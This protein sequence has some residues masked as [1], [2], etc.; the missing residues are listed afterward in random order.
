MTTPA[1]I[2]LFL[3]ILILLAVS[4]RSTH[5]EELQKNATTG[6]GRV[7]FV[8]QIQPIL[9]ARC[10]ACHG[11]EAQEAGLRLDFRKAALAGGD[12]GKV[13]VAGRSGASPL[14]AVLLSEDEDTRMPPVD[15]GRPL[16]PQ[17]VALIRAWIDQGAHWPEGVD[18]DAA[19][20][21]RGDDHWAYQALVRPE[22]PKLDNPWIRNDVDRFVLHRLQKEDVVPSPAAERQT[23]I[24]RLHLDLIGLP[25][26]P[27]ELQKWTK[28]ADTDSGWYQALVDHLLDSPHFGERWGRHWLDLARYADSDGYEKDRPRP[29]AW[30]WRDWVINAVNRDLPFDRFTIE[31]LAGDLLPDA[32]IE[33]KIATGFHRNTLTNSEGGVDQ[34]E[35][36]IKAVKDRVYTTGTVWLGLT[37]QCGE[38]HSHKFDPFSQREYYRLAAFFNNADESDIAAM[39]PGEAEAHQKA[40]ASFDQRLRE[41]KQSLSEADQSLPERQA[42]WERQ[43]LAAESSARKKIPS[44]ILDVIDTPAEQRDG[45]QTGELTE[46]Y[47]KIDTQLV[48]LNKELDE[49]TRNKPK[50]PQ[51]KAPAFAER[52]EPRENYVH[53]RGDF[54]RRGETV[55]PGTLE[56]LHEF[57]PRGEYPDRLD[58]AHWLVDKANPLTPRVAANRIWQH[59]F[60]RGIVETT[61]DFGT[62]GAPPTH[63]ELIDWLATEYIRQG[64]S[65]K[66]MIRLIVSSATYRQSS[67]A[68]PELQDRDPKNDLIARQNRFRM[69]AEI[70]RDLY[71]ASSGLLHRAIGGRSV[72]PALPADVAALGYAGSVKWRESPAPDRYRRGMYIFFRRSVPYPMLT[73]FDAPE[74]TVVSTRRDRSNTPLQSLTLLND[75]VFV[76]CAQTLARRVLKEAPAETNA[77]IR[78]AFLLCLSREPDAFEMARLTQ[79]HGQLLTLY[80]SDADAAQQMC[81][82]ESPADGAN[83]LADSA[84]WTALC[85]ALMNLDEFV[86]RE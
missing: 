47:R 78:R 50:P 8:K 64:W 32:T 65:R 44:H 10:Y 20:K 17:E 37:A 86:T 25:P 16:T 43:L 76:E 61:W 39:L 46:F 84:A 4:E 75:P 79:L 53:Q 72:Y 5:A 23:L 36:R 60:G 57:N 35:Y 83:A 9:R 82:Q 1:S 80:E 48:K 71:L 14:L 12:N 42:T 81:G 3:T 85:R 73:T 19:N 69:D 41:L 15:E 45:G 51:T 70:V 30:R 11:A 27:E 22:P 7:S 40:V 63:P 33:Q 21:R 55:T 54:R 62:Q 2:R 34:E 29:N 13:I 66:A 18:G 38:C 58:L 28:Q 49:H 67:A 74:S 52:G 24:R 77:R 68:R 31:Q 56:V 26:E 59:L 6:S